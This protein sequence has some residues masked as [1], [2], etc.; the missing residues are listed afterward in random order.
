MFGREKIDFRS[1]TKEQ[2]LK[3]SIYSSLAQ[4]HIEFFA[5]VQGHSMDLDAE[6]ISKI[7]RIYEKVLDSYL[8]KMGKGV[9]ANVRLLQRY[10]HLEPG[11][12]LRDS[13]L[14]EI[15]AFE[16]MLKDISESISIADR[17]K[18]IDREEYHE[19]MDRL[20]RMQKRFGELHSLS[21]Q[22]KRDLVLLEHTLT[23]ELGYAA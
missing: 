13:Y 18:T 2:E 1:K 10:I 8:L 11:K 17:K 3:S 14:R 21:D 5:H 23:E 15:R 6:K 12:D 7:L 4:K 16:L 20:S 9:E 22:I 19:I